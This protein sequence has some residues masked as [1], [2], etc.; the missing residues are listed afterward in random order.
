M[1]TM[2]FERRVDDNRGSNKYNRHLG[3]DVSSVPFCR[4]R[5][6]DS[7]HFLDECDGVDGSTSS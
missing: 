1:N 7:V 3:A 4:C 5:F 2:E 6:D